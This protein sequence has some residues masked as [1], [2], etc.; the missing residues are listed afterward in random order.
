MEQSRYWLLDLVCTS[1]F[2]LSILIQD[3]LAMIVNKSEG[4][5]LNRA[6]LV[7]TLQQLFEEGILKAYSYENSGILPMAANLKI[8]DIEDAI[9]GNLNIYYGLTSFGGEQWEKLSK[10]NWDFY[11]TGWNPDWNF[12]ASSQEYQ[13]EVF[14]YG[15]NRQVLERYLL[16]LQYK[17][18]IDILSDSKIWEAQIPFLVRYWKTLPSGWRINCRIKKTDR[19]LGIEMPSEYIRLKDR[20]ENWYTNPF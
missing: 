8:E 2:P 10:P 16:L 4:H 17:L 3:E 19:Y 18:N 12:V 7:S 15:S 1:T 20:V 13:E 14:F 9:S 11:V 5:G 6:E